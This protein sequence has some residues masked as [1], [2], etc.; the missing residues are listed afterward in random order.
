MFTKPT[1][2]KIKTDVI[3]VYNVYYAYKLY[4]GQRII[5]IFKCYALKR[6]FL[7]LIDFIVIQNVYKF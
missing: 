4:F 1:V 2:N 6:S 7:S 5:V 3:L